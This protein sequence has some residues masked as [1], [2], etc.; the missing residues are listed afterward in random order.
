MQA[1]AVLA[2]NRDGV[3]SVWAPG[4]PWRRALTGYACRS[5]ANDAVCG[6]GAPRFQVLQGE[7]EPGI[8]YCIHGTCHRPGVPE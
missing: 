6:C 1:R 7:P 3:W 5:D 4:Q 8:Q 2:P